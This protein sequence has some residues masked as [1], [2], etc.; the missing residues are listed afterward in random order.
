MSLKLDDLRKR[1]LQQQPQSGN[2]GPS[3]DTPASSR[4]ADS[5]RVVEPR[6]PEPTV[7]EA[8]VAKVVEMSSANGTNLAVASESEE[9]PVSIPARKSG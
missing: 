3:A 5:A 1:L 6:E 8:S 2:T 9:N 7:A 4:V